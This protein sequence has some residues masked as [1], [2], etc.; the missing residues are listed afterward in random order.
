MSLEKIRVAVKE[1]I[2]LRDPVSKKLITTEGVLV[3]KNAFWLRRLKSGDCHEIT[4]SEEK[5]ETPKTVEREDNGDL[6]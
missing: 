2:I 5:I 6:I 4:A 1:G 3:P